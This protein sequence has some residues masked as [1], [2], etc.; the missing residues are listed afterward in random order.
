MK[1][2]ADILQALDAFI[3]KY[4]KNLLVR[5]V[6]Y[7]VG[8][9]LTLFL[10]AVLL[11]H[12]GWLSSVARAAIFWGGL[13][14]V[15]AILGGLVVRPLLKM[16]GLGKRIDRPQAARIIGRHFPEVSDKLLNLLQLMDD[17]D[18]SE[19]PDLRSSYDKALSVSQTTS[20]SLLG[21]E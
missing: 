6:L 21:A 3:R 13:A 2:Q 12:F 5:G 8:I 16:M 11:E 14:A 7:A 4:Y 1:P 9:V 19:K 20:S 18:Y 10:A 17:S 15:A